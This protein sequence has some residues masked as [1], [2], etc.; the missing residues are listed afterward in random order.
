MWIIKNKEIH[1]SLEYLEYI[2]MHHC[3]S[4]KTRNSTLEYIAMHHCGSLK[5]RKSMLM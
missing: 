3:R 2:A 4:L 5:T 1:A